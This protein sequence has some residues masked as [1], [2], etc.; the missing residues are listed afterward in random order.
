MLLISLPVCERVCHGAPARRPMYLV[1]IRPFIS[2]RTLP[3]G[4]L[5]LTHLHVRRRLPRTQ[6]HTSSLTS[7]C[8]ACSCGQANPKYG[9]RPRGQQ[10]DRDRPSPSGPAC[11]SFP[12]C[13]FLPG[14]ARTR[15]RTRTRMRARCLSQNGYEVRFGLHVGSPRLG[16][17]GPVSSIRLQ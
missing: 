1:G 13:F 3:D 11:W 16:F 2:S 17:H 5:S 15:T 8:T 7:V 6:V 10:H 14:A 4:C 12:V 9:V